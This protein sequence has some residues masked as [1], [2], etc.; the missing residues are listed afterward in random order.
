MRCLSVV[1]GPF[2]A[3]GLVQPKLQRFVTVAVFTMA[4]L[5]EPLRRAAL[6]NLAR[7]GCYGAGGLLN[8]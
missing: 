5:Q 7:N 4:D 2:W 8:A 3:K 1:R 6:W